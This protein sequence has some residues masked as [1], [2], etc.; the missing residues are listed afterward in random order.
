[1][2][3]LAVKL[4][5]LFAVFVYAGFLFT[6]NLFFSKM[7]KELGPEAYTAIRERFMSRV[8]KVVPKSLVVA[9]L[10]GL[11]LFHESFGAV[12]PEGLSGFQLMLGLKAALG[13]WLGTRGILQVFFGIEPFVFKSHRLPFMLVIVIIAL[14]Q[15]MYHV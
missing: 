13:L 10:S 2:L 5:H 6:D 4:V 14:S 1:M 11:Y 7:A 3:Y 8:R 15:I 12:G 9:V